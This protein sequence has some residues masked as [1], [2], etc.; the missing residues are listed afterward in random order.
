MPIK[1]IEITVIKEDG[2][3]VIAGFYA[4]WGSADIITTN[5]VKNTAI[6]GM[7][8]QEI[9]PLKEKLDRQERIGGN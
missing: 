5:A 1:G 6:A 3:K 2:T 9:V 7:L 4:P 8:L